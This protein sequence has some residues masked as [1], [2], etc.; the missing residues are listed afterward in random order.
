V[1]LS[2]SEFGD[3]LNLIEDLCS[4]TPTARIVLVSG[5]ITASAASTARDRGADAVVEK[6]ADA[7]EYLGQTKASPT[8][9]FPTLD[10]MI[11]AHVHRALR[12]TEGNRTE[13]A[14]LLGI[15]RSTLTRKLRRWRTL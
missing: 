4:L 2:L 6:P 12:T 11:R 13:A 9:S 1:D 5:A 15:H 3:G 14:R 10:Q 8:P 7:M